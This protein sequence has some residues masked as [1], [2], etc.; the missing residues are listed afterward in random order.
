MVSVRSYN[1]ISLGKKPANKACS[2]HWTL[3]I[4]RDLQ[5]F[6][7][8]EFF[9]LSPAEVTQTVDLP[10]AK[11]NIYDTTQSASFH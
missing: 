2:V 6:S 4:L 9:L 11:W 7:G 8:F 10:L 3:R 1:D 5:A